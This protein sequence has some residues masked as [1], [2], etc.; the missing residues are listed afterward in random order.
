MQVMDT[1][2]KYEMVIFNAFEHE[3]EKK[4]DRHKICNLKPDGKG[5]LVAFIPE[6][7]AVSGRIVI[8]PVQEQ[9]GDEGEA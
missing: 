8:Q 1:D 5:G 7:L 6:G 9:G 4:W 3:G 2:Q